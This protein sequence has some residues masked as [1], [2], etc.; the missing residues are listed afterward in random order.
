M[1]SEPPIL[2]MTAS[3]SEDTIAWANHTSTDS[4][5]TEDAPVKH[6]ARACPVG[7]DILGDELILEK[8]SCKAFV[9]SL[10][11]RLYTYVTTWIKGIF[12]YITILMIRMIAIAIAYSPLLV[13]MFA[14]FPRSYHSLRNDVCNSLSPDT[15]FLN[16]Y[17]AV[18]RCGVFVAPLDLKD[19]SFLELRSATAL[20][21]PFLEEFSRGLVLP[22]ELQFCLSP[23][24]DV[25]KEKISRLESG[26]RSSGSYF[27]AINDD[28][29]RLI[30]R[31]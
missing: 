24:C 20:A 4:S 12:C 16:V 3:L 5:T 22:L 10:P 28:I 26:M 30:D 25:M 2:D 9:G 7:D 6:E 29:R 13:S 14:E 27:V 15:P 8:K 21:G 1:D 11:S 31:S 18:F 23:E 19:P 17:G